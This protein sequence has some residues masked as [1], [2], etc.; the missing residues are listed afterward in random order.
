MNKLDKTVKIQ[1]QSNESATEMLSFRRRAKER[2]HKEY[3]ETVARSKELQA[4]GMSQLEAFE[5]MMAEMT[6]G[7]HRKD[8]EVWQ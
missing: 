8:Q 5:T 3:M 4:Q 6:Y 7:S 1:S 2:F